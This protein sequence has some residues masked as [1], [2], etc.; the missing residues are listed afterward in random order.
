[1]AAATCH[2]SLE[3]RSCEL[4]HVI[5]L[6]GVTAQSWFRFYLQHNDLNFDLPGSTTRAKLEY[7]CHPATSRQ[8]SSP[9]SS[10]QFHWR[11]SGI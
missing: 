11:L 6:S 2:P 1:V 10:E 4:D 7:G 5:R 8:T 3:R 9:V